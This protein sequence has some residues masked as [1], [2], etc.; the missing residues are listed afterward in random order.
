[1]NHDQMAESCQRE[2]ESDTLALEE[3]I[4]T[5][6]EAND[7]IKAARERIETNK[8]LLKALRPTKRTRK[9]SQKAQPQPE[10]AVPFS[11]S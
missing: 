2:I 7:A 5:R 11:I 9:P 6:K 4:Q 10:A 8:R 3:L 1:M